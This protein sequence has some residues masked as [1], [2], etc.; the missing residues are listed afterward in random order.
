MRAAAKMGVDYMLSQNIVGVHAQV[1][2]HE[3]NRIQ[4]KQHS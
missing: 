3:E 4:N 1:R 2:G